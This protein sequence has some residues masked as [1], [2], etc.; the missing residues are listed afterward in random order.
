MSLVVPLVLLT[1]PLAALALKL[2]ERAVIRIGRQ[3][4]L[5]IDGEDDKEATEVKE[6]EV[7]CHSCERKS[8]ELVALR[9]QI[10]VAGSVTNR[11]STSLLLDPALIEELKLKLECKSTK[12]A[13]KVAVDSDVL[14]LSLEDGQRLVY[15]V[16]AP[17]PPTPPNASP[18]SP[19]GL[20]RLRSSI[21]VTPESPLSSESSSTANSPKCGGDGTGV[22]RRNPTFEERDLEVRKSCP[23]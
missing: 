6:L 2:L 23:G 15:P 5:V 12:V 22:F 3:V 10:K 19:K 1:E 9:E 4:R 17:L 7:V 18:A 8:E 16:N 21:R 14:V 20:T 11:K 13:N